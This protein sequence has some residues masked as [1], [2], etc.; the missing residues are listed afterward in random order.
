MIKIGG[1]KL[2]RVWTDTWESEHYRLR[3][4]NREGKVFYISYRIS[5]GSRLN[6][7]KKL[8]DLMKNDTVEKACR[9]ADYFLTLG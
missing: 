9:S 5:D 8:E 2:N 4:M 6:A 1:E 3:Q 7:S